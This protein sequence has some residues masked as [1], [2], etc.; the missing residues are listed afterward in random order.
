M[1]LIYRCMG[2]LIRFV[3][4]RD[5][6]VEN[7]KTCLTRF[8]IVLGA[9]AGVVKSLTVRLE[10]KGYHFS[11]NSFLSTATKVIVS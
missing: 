10:A 3:K 6:A 1:F 5:L 7:I 8:R 9:P 2:T 4:N 11:K